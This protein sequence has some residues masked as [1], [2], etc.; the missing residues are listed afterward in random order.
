MVPVKPTP[1]HRE[2]VYRSAIHTFG[3][4]MQFLKLREEIAELQV[5]MA[6]YEL[7]RDNIDSVVEEVAD[8]IIM[9]SQARLILG[10]DVVDAVIEMKLARLVNTI[11]A[12]QA[13]RGP[14]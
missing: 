14:R 11:S 12:V 5:A 7:S 6:R 8:V 10:H 3:S 13:G 4:H 1:L 2:S 9:T